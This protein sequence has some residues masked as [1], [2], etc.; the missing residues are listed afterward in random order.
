MSFKK[1]VCVDCGS[2]TGSNSVF[3]EEAKNMGTALA[4]NSIGL[5]YGGGSPGLMHEI[6]NA[7]LNRGG[8]RFT[9]SFRNICMNSKLSINS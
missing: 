6:A 7:A 2:K 4:S 9:E 8:D 3:T 1:R 5:V